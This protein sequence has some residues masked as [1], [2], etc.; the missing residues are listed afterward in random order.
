MLGQHAWSGVV[1]GTT[2]D[3]FLVSGNYLAFH[4][5][6]PVP[7]FRLYR[8]CSARNAFMYLTKA[9]TTAGGSS[10]LRRAIQ[11]S[12]AVPGD[13]SGPAWYGRQCSRQARERELRSAKC[14]TSLLRSFRLE[15]SLGH[16]AFH[17]VSLNSLTMR[18]RKRSQVLAAHA[19]LYRS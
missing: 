15:P 9:R 19:R 10:P 14:A 6:P 8:F 11:C 4:C 12:V 1:A 17:D 3:S 5:K 18:A 16:G 7:L 13:H 2:R